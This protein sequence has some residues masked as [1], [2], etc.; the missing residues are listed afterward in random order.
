MV[1]STASLLH[2]ANYN[3]ICTF[4]AQ[5]ALNVLDERADVDVVLSDVRMPEYTGFDLH[6][7]MRY[8]WPTV[9]IVLVT[10]F[11]IDAS[12]MAPRGAVIVQ[13]PFTLEQLDEVI[14]R[15]LR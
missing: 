2:R 5:E 12:D 4:S 10:G 13:K 15:R 11:D 9:P 6:R 14:K 7:V 8:R 3:V 1:E